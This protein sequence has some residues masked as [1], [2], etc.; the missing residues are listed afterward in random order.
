MRDDR[1]L[2]ESL[3]AVT[4]GVIDDFN[5]VDFLRSRSCTRCCFHT[6]I[7]FEM[8]K[9]YSTKRLYMFT[10]MTCTVSQKAMF[11]NVFMFEM[12]PSAN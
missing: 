12:H 11:S 10:T 7:T 3:R 5:E 8:V 1:A 2:A 9:S 4:S 6:K